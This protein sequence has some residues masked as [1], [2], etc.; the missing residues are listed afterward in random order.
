MADAIDEYFIEN[1][2]EWDYKP[3]P[4][5]WRQLGEFNKL[6]KQFSWPQDRR[7]TQLEKLKACWQLAMEEEFAGDTLDHFQTLCQDLGISPIP[8]TVNKCR[9]AL[10]G[11]FVNIV[12]LVQYRRDKRA[13]G[14]PKPVTL[15]HTREELVE[16]TRSTGRF[17][18]TENARAAMLR[19]LLVM[20]Q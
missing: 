2:P 6:A 17:Y 9:T 4:H 20:G 1:F 5:D 16:Y 11:V 15:F 13:G 12:D 18:P 10:S 8:D 19:V 14:N 7:T 3:S